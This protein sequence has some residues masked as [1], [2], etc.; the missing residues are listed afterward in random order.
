MI[1]VYLPVRAGVDPVQPARHAQAGLVET[2]H[3]AGG[4]TVAELG[5]ELI[6]SIGGAFDHG[7]HGAF[8]DRGGVVNMNVGGESS[9]M[10]VSLMAVLCEEMEVVWPSGVALRGGASNRPEVR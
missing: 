9:E 4:N 1:R 3:L 8:G 7:G 5:E 2:G 6:E 10:V